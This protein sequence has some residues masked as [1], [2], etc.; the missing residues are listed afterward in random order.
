M[1]SPEGV[2]DEPVTLTPKLRTL[3]WLLRIGLSR[4]VKL[5]RVFQSRFSVLK[6]LLNKV[7][8]R[9]RTF[10]WVCKIVTFNPCNV[11][12]TV[13]PA[14]LMVLVLTAVIFRRPKRN[15]FHWGAVL[16][17]K[18]C[19][20]LERQCGD[21]IVSYFAI[22]KPNLMSDYSAHLVSIIRAGTGIKKSLDGLHIG[23]RCR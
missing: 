8:Q 18:I 3:G 22:P 16:E 15:G 1:V 11:M 17:K 23:C 6:Y 12:S 7:L 2:A 5:I 9:G 14:C 19:S 4:R 21:L 20:I 10:R 13:F